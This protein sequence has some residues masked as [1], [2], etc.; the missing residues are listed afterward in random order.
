MT[1]NV[2]CIW[3]NSTYLE[4]FKTRIAPFL[5]D[6]AFNQ[7]IKNG[8]SLRFAKIARFFINGRDYRIRTCDLLTPSE[9]RYQ[10]ALS[11]V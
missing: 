3:Q 11:P 10:A 8:Q 2:S 4:T 7:S 6:L 5:P 9:A 1:K